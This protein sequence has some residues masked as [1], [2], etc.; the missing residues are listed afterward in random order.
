VFY[1]IIQLRFSTVIGYFADVIDGASA[2]EI[3]V[4][5]VNRVMQFRGEECFP[6]G[7]GWSRQEVN[8]HPV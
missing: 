8:E 7:G 2:V 1:Q 4:V 5:P 6:A 3:A